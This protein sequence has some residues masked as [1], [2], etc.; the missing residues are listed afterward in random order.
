VLYDTVISSR[1]RMTS[2]GSAT[3]TNPFP[4]NVVDD[5]PLRAGALPFRAG[6]R[7]PR[8]ARMFFNV[9]LRLAARTTAGPFPP[10]KTLTVHPHQSVASVRR[11]RMT[12]TLVEQTRSARPSATSGHAARAR[13]VA[14]S[15]T[16]DQCACATWSQPTRGSM[17][18]RFVP[19]QARG[20]PG[21]R[22][23]RQV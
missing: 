14:A 16:A 6:A 2:A 23:A 8:L 9:D 20:E 1:Q 13:A 11:R 7:I 17:A 10:R 21:S 3:P 18:S 22:W 4:S 15:R 12:C 5:D 19:K